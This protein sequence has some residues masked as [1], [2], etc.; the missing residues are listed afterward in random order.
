MPL[1]N[2]T[3]LINPRKTHAYLDCIMHYY[4]RFSVPFKLKLTLKSFYSGIFRIIGV[5]RKKLYFYDFPVELYMD[6]FF[7]SIIRDRNAV[8]V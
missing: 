8:K 2:Y 7:K 1:E 3:K 4:H 5:I 6:S